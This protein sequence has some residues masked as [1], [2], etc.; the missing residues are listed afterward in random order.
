MGIRDYMKGNVGVGL[1][2]GAGALLL[3][4]VVLPVLAGILKTTTKA[5]VKTGATLYEKGSETVAELW[6]IAKDYAAETKEELAGEP[7]VI[8]VE[9]TAVEVQPASAAEGEKAV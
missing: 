6:T 4:P 5:V 9:S 3:A 7:E 8:D 1:L 2:V